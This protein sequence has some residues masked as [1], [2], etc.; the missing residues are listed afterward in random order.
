MDFSLRP[1]NEL[2][3]KVG[4]MAVIVIFEKNR[5][6]SNKTIRRL[7]V[8][9]A[10]AILG[11]VFI[12]AYYMI[13]TWNLRDQ[14][15]D[16]SARIALRKTAEQIATYNNARLPKQNII[17]RRSSNTYVVNI[18]DE[19]DARILEDYL[20]QNFEKRSLEA[21]FEYGIYDC[22]S[23]NMLYGDYCDIGS[24]TT[25]R[26]TKTRGEL[27][28]FKDLEYYFVV[29][30]PSR[31]GY[32][33]SNM[34]QAL[35]FSIIALLAISFFIY[36]TVIILR[37]RRLSEMQRDFINNMTHEFKTPISSIKLAANTIGKDQSIQRDNRL[38]KYVQLIDEQSTRLNDQVEKLLSI[39]AVERRNLELQLEPINLNDL[40]TDIVEDEELR[41]RDENGSIEF[42]QE[43]HDV[44]VQADK[45]HLTNVL[46]SL[47]DNAIKYSK[48]E[49]SIHVTLK[50]D[51]LIISDK[52]IGIEKQHLSM[53][54]KKFY[55]VPTGN[56]HDVKGFGLGLYYVKTII[57]KL[58][59]SINVD[60]EMNQGTDITI[61]FK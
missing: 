13:N 30:F 17:Q 27:P 28:T 48:E 16:A 10:F 52:G 14:A 53:I 23:N 56:V 54:F 38:Q 12:Q 2:L 39:A 7:L 29:R 31:A 43:A 3:I 32:L 18:N 59:W 61:F 47:L 11:I 57:H 19:I 49:V 33:L 42:S 22:G 60:S 51:R 46:Y 36:A 24:G 15:F 37:Q 45:M 35:L 55:R 26:D 4:S 5:F 50:D 1:V 34:R 8:L 41:I 58:G 44:S 40:L 21:D 25:D 20:I 9:G 6:V